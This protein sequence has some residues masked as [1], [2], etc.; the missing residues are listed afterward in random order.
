MR[1]RA[2][3]AASHRA[4]HFLELGDR[5]S[6][7]PRGIV[8][9]IERARVGAASEV[10]AELWLADIQL[11]GGAPQRRVR[12]RLGADLRSSTSDSIKELSRDR[13]RQCEIDLCNR[14][15]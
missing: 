2:G 5:Y 6:L 11:D 12:A 1:R 14:C 4:A 15:D 8:G 9:A 3:C 13:T 10:A 7:G